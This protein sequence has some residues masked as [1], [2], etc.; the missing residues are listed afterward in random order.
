MIQETAKPCSVLSKCSTTPA[1]FRRRCTVLPATTGSDWAAVV[2]APEIHIS[3]VRSVATSPSVDTR[4][5]SYAG[6]GRKGAKRMPDEPTSARYVEALTDETLLSSRKANVT[7]SMI[8]PML[9][10]GGS[11]GVPADDLA[12][13]IA[14]CE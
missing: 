7:R 11:S 12:G 13:A 3:L 1:R 10:D 8:S 9:M 2:A 4:P 14:A 6:S 5:S